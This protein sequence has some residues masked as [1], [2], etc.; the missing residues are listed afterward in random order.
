MTLDVTIDINRLRDYSTI[1]SRSEVMSWL[2]GD[3]RSLDTKIKRYSDSTKP[4]YS[5]YLEFIKFTY[6]VLQLHYQNEYVYKNSFLNHWLINELGK[7]D[8]VV[9]NE[10][11]VGKSVADLA[12]FNGISKAFEIKTE[13]DSDKRLSTQIADYKRAFN[14]VFLIIPSSK[15]K[16][17]EKY[18]SEIG[19][20]LFDDSFKNKFEL[21]RTA[22]T[23]KN[24]EP[25]VLMDLLHTA[26]YKAIVDEYFGEL[27]KMNS[28]NQYE[29][30]K[31][32]IETIPIAELNGMYLEQLKKR[33]LDNVLSSHSFKELNQICLALKL[34]KQEKQSLIDILKT[35]L[36]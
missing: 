2:K 30:C 6:R 31:T 18:D 36:S 5:N 23:R 20:I 22:S 16:L 17:Y 33:K 4:S 28:F 21:Y 25:L 1:F 10:F 24:I 35:P 34:K 7:S 29:T 32:L 27:P 14:E 15:I 9:F 8:S 13:F 26:E 12:M 19:I 3:F 11:R